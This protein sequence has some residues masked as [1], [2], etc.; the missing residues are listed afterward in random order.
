MGR[1]QTALDERVHRM[2]NNETF[3]FH[4]AWSSLDSELPALENIPNIRYSN[5][6]C[7]TMHPIQGKVDNMDYLVWS[8]IIF[9]LVCRTKHL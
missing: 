6:I 4:V 7:A 2:Q 3:D 9:F 8:W 5:D 1:S